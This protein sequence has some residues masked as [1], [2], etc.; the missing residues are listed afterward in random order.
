MDA[1]HWEN[2]HQ[3][4]SYV[5]P[6]AFSYAIKVCVVLAANIAPEHSFYHIICPTIETSYL[7]SQSRPGYA[8]STKLREDS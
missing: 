8:C 3:L 4:A 1:G 5:L 2:I 7:L 6:E